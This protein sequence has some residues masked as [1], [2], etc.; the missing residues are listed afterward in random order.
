MRNINK[1]HACTESEKRAPTFILSSCVELMMNQRS[2]HAYTTS[3]L[4]Y[5]IH[6]LN[7][8][9]NSTLFCCYFIHHPCF[10][11][12]FT[13]RLTFVYIYLYV[14][15]YRLRTGSS[16]IKSQ[17]TNHILD[18]WEGCHVTSIATWSK[19]SIHTCHLP[20]I[21]FLLFLLLLLHTELHLTID[22]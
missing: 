16:S 8:I 17:K 2:S 20:Y 14:N 1:I 3:G 22:S 19:E 11:L 13:C 12:L 18:G 9:F 7:Y 15:V 5:N 4:L 21:L 6:W 10:I